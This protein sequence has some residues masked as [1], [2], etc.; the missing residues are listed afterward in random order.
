LD[1]RKLK[2]LEKAM[3]MEGGL[4]LWCDRHR[5][6]GAPSVVKGQIKRDGQV[7]P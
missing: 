7:R 6:Q 3:K 2:R 5:A 4:K 1:L